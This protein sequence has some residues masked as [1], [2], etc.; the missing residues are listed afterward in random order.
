MPG[1][2]TGD[3][4]RGGNILNDIELHARVSEAGIVPTLMAADPDP[5][6]A[7]RIADVL[8]EAGATVI[9]ILF[10][11]P[12][13]A[14]ALAI[15]KRRHPTMLVAAGTVLEAQDVARAEA[16]G[17][18]FLISPGLS[19]VLHAAAQA[20]A[21]A[22]ALRQHRQRSA[23]RARSVLQSAE[24]LPGLGPGSSTPAPV[25]G[26]LSR[27]LFPGD[28]RVGLGNRGGICR[29]SEC[30]RLGRALVGRQRGQRSSA[31][32]GPRY[33]PVSTGLGGQA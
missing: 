23:A 28:R 26:D 29:A 1:H 32:S 18:D 17:A 31:R 30:R 12:R 16:S 21:P 22:G 27:R 7:T 10:R 9:E 13:A 24:A 19:P 5:E 15:I 6:A 2:K 8:A 3:L 4:R 14:D 20:S 25:R 11:S 33:F